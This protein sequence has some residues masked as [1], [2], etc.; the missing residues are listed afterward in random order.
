MRPCTIPLNGGLDCP[1][2]QATQSVI[3]NDVICPNHLVWNQWSHWGAC[4]Q[5][6]GPGGQQE[7]SRS[8]YSNQGGGGSCPSEGLN[9]TQGCNTGQCPIQG[10][11]MNWSEWGEC[12]KTCET[13][14]RERKRECY[15]EASHCTSG[16]SQQTTNCN[17]DPCPVNGSWLEW[18]SWEACSAECGGGTRQRSRACQDPLHGGNTCPMSGRFDSESCNQENCPVDGIWLPWSDWTECTLTCQTGTKTHQRTCYGPFFGGDECPSIESSESVDCNTQECPV[19]GVW[20]NWTNWSE[21]SL[22]C[23]TGT[24][25]RSRACD[26]PFHDGADCPSEE[27]QETQNCNE[28]LCPVDGTWLNW[29]TW[30]DCSEP[31]GTGSQI[32]IRGCYGPFH[33]GNNCPSD[34]GTE[35]QDCNTQFCPVD[36]IWSSWQNWSLCSTTC[37]DGTRSRTRPCFGPFHLGQPCPLGADLEN[38]SCNLEEC[39]G[40]S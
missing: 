28:E 8:C 11:W 4:S 2:D 39:E 19:D 12:S 33:N 22:T 1:T 27:G 34:E 20:L 23:Q 16:E 29:S 35:S 26:G 18:G 13:G 15:G 37:G 30:Q 38:E 21:C 32:R 14:T 40:K 3:C 10:S 5:T 17:T 7:R 25:S 31:C 6:C 24:Q 36:G 9:Q